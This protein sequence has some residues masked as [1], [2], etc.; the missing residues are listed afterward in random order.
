MQI[1]TGTPVGERP[2]G[3]SWEKESLTA[4]V[5]FILETH[6]VYTRSA[7]ATLPP[8]AAK[9]RGRHGDAHPET[10]VVERLVT[11]LVEDLEPHLMKE[12]QILFP[13]V[14][15]LEA[16]AQT[17]SCFGTVRNPIRVMLGE[18]EA[19]EGILGELR[20]V[21]GSYALPSDACESF[22]ALYTGLEDFEADLHRHIRIEND[23]LFPGAIALET[24]G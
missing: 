12:E 21:T 16:G 4:V 20:A 8:L 24:T 11:R 9:V 15:S 5:K 22:Q 2:F 1:E 19:V 10:V 14:L 3:R 17:D 6:H 23:I 18:H 7:I 13:Y